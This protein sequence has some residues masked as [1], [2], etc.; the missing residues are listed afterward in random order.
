MASDPDP[1]VARIKPPVTVF[2]R[3]YPPAF[4]RGG[5]ARS[6]HALVEALAAEFEFS[7]VTSSFD[8]M[9]AGTMQSVKPGQWSIF[10]H[11]AVWYEHRQR[12]P[13][14]TI[15]RLL[16]ETKPQVVYLNSLFD[17]SFA[18]LPLLITQ[19]ISR[20]PSVILAPRGELSPGALTLKH[21]KK[22]A[23]IA[24]FRL[25][26]LHRAVTWHASTSHEKADIERVFG[27]SVRS[28]VAIDLRAGLDDGLA[29]SVETD[30]PTQGQSASL[31]FLSRIVPKKNVAAA[32]R[33]MPLV[34]GDAHLTI[35]GPIED[36]KYWKHCLALIA[37]MADPELIK[38][39]GV[40]PADEVVAFLG[41][42]D[43]FVFPTLGENFGHVVLESLAA[44]T[45]VIVGRD[46]PWR[47]LEATGAGWLCDPTNPKEIADLI[48]QFTSMDDAARA[49]MREAAY[50]LA[51]EVLN[52]PN[53]INSNRSM[54]QAHTFSWSA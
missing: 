13:A 33:A 27:V 54:F 20:R 30:R 44:G 5:P 35:A 19:S 41:R 17:Y 3:S 34:D 18:I 14:R 48:K 32:I 46:T 7:V 29:E 6:V 50:R 49:R 16:R 9:T 4:L 43:L 21:R 15:A 51:R 45:P 22:Q 10:G 47:Q 8:D 40:V 38:Y 42:F 52:D 2:T 24:V 1:K 39:G 36:T 53:A 12:M 37:N 28:H 31:V 23:F 26:R 25:L 11:A